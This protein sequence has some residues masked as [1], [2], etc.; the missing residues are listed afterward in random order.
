MR[1]LLVQMES[2]L[3]LVEEEDPAEAAANP[4]LRPPGPSGGDGAKPE[5]TP[6]PPEDPRGLREFAAAHAAY[7]RIFRDL[8]LVCDQ[9]CHPQK[10]EAVKAAMEA[11]AGR[12]LETRHWMVRLNDDV[13]AL[14]PDDVSADAKRTP[15]AMELPVPRCFVGDR[16]ESIEARETFVRQHFLRTD[17]KEAETPTRTA[18]AD[19]D[20]SGAASADASGAASAGGGGGGSA[21]DTEA[22]AKARAKR[23]AIE[24]LR[25]ARCMK[26]PGM[27]EEDALR[28]IQRNERG[29]Q[30]RALSAALAATRRERELADAS[31]AKRRSRA[32]T[33][34]ICQ[35]LVRGFLARRR[36][37]R[38]RD[39]EL[40]FL[41][42]KLPPRLERTTLEESRDAPRA[43]DPGWAGG[44]VSKKAS[45]SAKNAVAL[46]DAT[47]AAR[48][49]RVREAR[50]FEMERATIE[51]RQTVRQTEGRR[52]RETVQDAIEVWFAERRDPITGAYPA[53][54]GEDEGGSRAIV[55]P[56]PAR[57]PP[58]TDPKAKAARGKREAE[59]RKKAEAEAKKRA[60]RAKKKGVVEAEPEKKGAAPVAFVRVLRDALERYRAEWGEVRDLA[61]NFEQRHDA[62]RVANQLRPA[63]FE[64]VR[65]ET[66]AEMRETLLRLKE[67]VAAERGGAGG[68]GG[69]GEAEAGGGGGKGKAEAGG[70][71]GKGKAEAGGGGKKKKKKK[72]KKE[73]KK[74]KGKKDFATDRTLESLYAELCRC[75]VARPL[76]GAGVDKFEAETTTASRGNEATSASFPATSSSPFALASAFVGVPQTASAHARRR[77]VGSGVFPEP[78]LAHARQ[79]VAAHVSLPL[80]I[81]SAAKAKLPR[82]VKSVLLYGARGTGKSFLTREA[83][84]VAGAAVFDMSPGVI[85]GRY[86]GAKNTA[87]LVR[88][89]FRV[90]K[91]CA[92]S[93]VVMDDA[94]RVF[95]T[96]TKKTR[97]L[98]E[99]RLRDKPSTID[100]PNRV[101]KALIEEMKALKRADRVVLVGHARAPY[102]CL[103]KD[104]KALLSFFDAR[105]HTPTPDRA[106]RSALFAKLT[107]DFGGGEFPRGFQ[108]AALVAASENYSAGAI[109]TAVRETLSPRALKK[110]RDDLDLD[111]NAKKLDADDF[112]RRLS[113][114][115]PPVSREERSE[116]R[117]W[118]RS[119]PEYAA[120]EKRLDPPPPPDASDD[121]DAEGKKKKGK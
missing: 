39:E 7:V 46:R 61:D 38:A 42:M 103:K 113:R 53:F 80:G 29:R 84:R 101:K 104:R 28:L 93:V 23:E 85:D 12:V 26:A 115:P 62:E 99:T 43:A 112:L 52:M 68:G 118:T 91:L 89:T 107:R 8:E 13:E 98:L 25:A 50:R 32:E 37:R 88:M 24:A 70:G 3:P 81:S 69:K 86:P 31:L 96:D 76:D 79:S 97:E 9:M 4:V 47:N 108:S 67:T 21:E 106:T 64:E 30:G 44:A 55:D 6:E 18:D 49:R 82:H 110:L 1:D 59:A 22:A 119:L 40:A 2:E 75:G 116:L 19:A 57:P 100:T 73:K 56:P 94:E 11:C 121:E 58:P 17:T 60:E 87:F 15:D 72:K 83:A 27:P 92:P 36:V 20:A 16:A 34:V 5:E 35:A 63:V 109:E 10:R 54:P 111:G 41:G 95:L 65:V 51:L 14:A 33:A 105:V 90:A 78:T 71:G 66:D 120:L 77:A 102:A 45:S 48:R 114:G 74:E 117:D